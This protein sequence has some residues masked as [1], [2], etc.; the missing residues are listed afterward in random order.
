MEMNGNMSEATP[1]WDA[2]GILLF[3]DTVKAIFSAG[4]GSTAVRR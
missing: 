1:I 4:V 3:R 2:P